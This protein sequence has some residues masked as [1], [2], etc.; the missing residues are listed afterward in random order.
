MSAKNPKA[1]LNIAR[2]TA[3]Y[4]PVEERTSDYAE[5]EA[6]LPIEELVRQAER[7]MN[8]GI[9]FCHGIGCPLGN[10]IPDFNAAA[11]RGDWR[12]AW[13]LLSKTSPF[14]EFTSR[15]CP[16]LCEGSCTAGLEFGSVAVRQIERR[17]VETA[18][19]NGW[20]NGGEPSKRSG[21][22]ISVV[23]SG[24]A[25]LAAADMLNRC[26]HKVTVYERNAKPGGL[27]RYGIPDFK[28]AK[29]VV[30]RRAKLMA[31]S[32]IDFVCRTEIGS[33]VSAR[34]LT[35]KRDAL[36]LAVG[37]PTPRDLSI[38]GRE[39][40]GIYFALDFLAGENRVL[41]GELSEPPIS[42]AGKRV[43]I[44]GGGDT[45]S[46]CAGTSF[47]QGA[48]S[49]TQIEIMPKPPIE[50]SA[51]TPWPEWPYLLR[52]SS[53]HQEGVTR[54]W[55][56]ASKRF[57][58]RDGVLAG[59]EVEPVVWSFSD[60]GR[61]SRF[62]PETGKSEVIEAD[63][64]LLAMGFL[65]SDRAATLAKFGLSESDSLFLAGDALNG[66]SLV[67]RAIADGR[68]IADQIDQRLQ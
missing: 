19:E 48:A 3:P 54:R 34:Y 6:P 32:G 45:G 47:R 61:P 5:V 17:I 62:E 58:A 31:E 4:R 27:L 66:P 26:G 42:A 46:D 67:V 59:V 24:P 63:L 21:R 41:D 49:V 40:P 1:F 23:G 14:P 56:L 65:K 64:I 18:F 13:E 28:L 50:R 36:L 8:C 37:T 53:S 68:R 11:A 30:D 10:L 20:V 25:G 38:P 16:A 43:L 33:D 51:S 29:S 57:I 15:V 52:T 55:S 9:P 12:T 60:S 39:L 7:C 2:K 22:L 44:I 35:G